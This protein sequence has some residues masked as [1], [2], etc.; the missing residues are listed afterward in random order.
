MRRRAA[1]EQP[2]RFGYR[3]S[4][5]GFYAWEEDQQQA[6]AWGRELNG[7][8]VGASFEVESHEQAD[9]LHRD[10]RNPAD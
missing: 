8:P 2:A 1:A 5:P 6:V 4:G 7:Q 10:E 3:I 9:P